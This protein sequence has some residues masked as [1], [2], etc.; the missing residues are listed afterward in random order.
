MIS[1]RGR[2]KQTK[3]KLVS[4]LKIRHKPN[5]KKKN[6]L[7]MGDSDSRLTTLEMIVFGLSSTVGELVE[8]LRLTNLAKVSASG[9]RQSLLKKK[10]VKEDDG[11]KRTTEIDSDSSDAESDEERLVIATDHQLDQVMRHQAPEC[12]L[13]LRIQVHLTFMTY[14]VNRS[15]GIPHR[16]LQEGHPGQYVHFF[17]VYS[18][19]ASNFPEVIH[20]MLRLMDIFIPVP[21][22]MIEHFTLFANQMIEPYDRN[23]SIV[24]ALRFD[25]NFVGLVVFENQNRGQVP[26]TRASIEALERVIYDAA[27]M[28][29]PCS[30]CLVGYPTGMEVTRMPCSH[31]YH[32][33]CII[34]WLMISNL[35]PLCRF[36]MP[37]D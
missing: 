11:E 16:V 9:K 17:W 7:E 32:R 20:Q 33:D 3:E 27:T 28:S 15:N 2:L 22:R 8:K 12:G 23:E 18:D 5:S 21:S 31:I 30:I 19:Q 6:N 13:L 34:H 25:I 24:L 10:G 26:A 29:N 14:W 1:T 35:C 36:A 4:P 37:T